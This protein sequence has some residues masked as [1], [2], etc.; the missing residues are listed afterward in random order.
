MFF[1]ENRASCSTRTYL[2]VTSGRTLD[3]LQRH[4]NSEHKLPAEKLRVKASMKEM[5][6]VDNECVRK[7]LSGF[8]DYTMPKVRAFKGEV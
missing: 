2:K 5:G 6:A 1:E 3:A 8:P 4:Y 7:Y